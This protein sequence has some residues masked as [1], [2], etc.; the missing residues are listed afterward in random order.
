MLTIRLNRDTF[1]RARGGTPIP[2]FAAQIGV[3]KDSMYRAYKG[4]PVSNRVQAHL[5]AATTETFSELFD[6]VED[7]NAG[8]DE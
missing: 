2:Q 3:S 5:L 7:V 4:N 1:D 8:D 6:V